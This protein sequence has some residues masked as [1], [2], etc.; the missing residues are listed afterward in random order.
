MQLP[1]GIGNLKSSLLAD[2]GDKQAGVYIDTGFCGVYNAVS[3]FFQEDHIG[4]GKK[5]VRNVTKTH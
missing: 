5:T 4:S 3:L 2:P 1:R